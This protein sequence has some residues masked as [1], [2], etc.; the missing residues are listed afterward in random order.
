MIQVVV[1]L[2]LLAVIA[3]AVYSYR[4]EIRY[5][6]N[7]FSF[8]SFTNDKMEIDKSKLW[9]DLGVDVEC[10]RCGGKVE[11]VSFHNSE[12]PFYSPMRAM[13][14]FGSQAYMCR[15]CGIVFF[16]EFGSTFS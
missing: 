1:V 9:D 15:A 13:R 10:P 14:P 2:I 3:L 7:I 16:D 11:K 12:F 6:S 5:L 4:S 8:K